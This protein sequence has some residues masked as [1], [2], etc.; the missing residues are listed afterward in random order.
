MDFFF[1][2]TSKIA[3]ENKKIAQNI[4]EERKYVPKKRKKPNC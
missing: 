3:K 2:E 1:K 4:I